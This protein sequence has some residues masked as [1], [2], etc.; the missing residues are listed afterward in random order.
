DLVGTGSGGAVASLNAHIARRNDGSI[1]TGGLAIEAPA[2]AVVASVAQAAGLRDESRFLGWRLN[3]PFGSL[4]LAA[5]GDADVVP[6]D[7]GLT[8]TVLGPE[9][10]RVA[11]LQ[12]EWAQKVG[13]AVAPPAAEVAAIADR[14]VYNLS[15]IIALAEAGGRRM[16]LTGDARGDDITNGLRAAG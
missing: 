5:R 3:R 15:S 11:K 8:L 9:Q 4:V 10:N 6:L 16:L 12:E 7:G 13:H 1:D 14:S 2:A